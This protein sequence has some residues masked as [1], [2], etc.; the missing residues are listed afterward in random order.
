M[1][2]YFQLFFILATLAPTVLL[3]ELSLVDL[4]IEFAAT[5]VKHDTID[6]IYA[7]YFTSGEGAKLP[8][9]LVEKVH[10]KFISSY[11]WVYYVP[12]IIPCPKASR[13]TITITPDSK[14]IIMIFNS[15]TIENSHSICCICEKNS[16]SLT[17]LLDISGNTISGAINMTVVAPNSAIIASATNKGKIIIWEKI[18]LNKKTIWH[19]TATI[20]TNDSIKS[21]EFSTDSQLLVAKTL[22]NNKIHIFSKN[23]KSLKESDSR[24]LINTIESETPY[25]EVKLSPDSQYII[26]TLE[27]VSTLYLWDRATNWQLKELT[28]HQD[29]VK[30]LTILNNGNLIVSGSEDGTLRVWERAKDW[31]ST[32]LTTYTSPIIAITKAYDDSFF[33]P[34]TEDDTL[35]VWQEETTVH[36]EKTK[37]SWKQT[38]L[39]G[40]SD[41]VN[42]MGVTPDNSSI[43]VG[44][45]DTLYIYSKEKNWQNPTLAIHNSPPWTTL[46]PLTT[47]PLVARLEND[48]CCIWEKNDTW[49]STLMTDNSNNPNS[50]ALK[51]NRVGI[52]LN[53][54]FIVST[55]QTEPG[56]RI[57]HKQ[58]KWISTY[59]LEHDVQ[60]TFTIAPD[61]SYIASISSAGVLCI[62]TPGSIAYILCRLAWEKA[63]DTNE[64]QAVRNSTLFATLP[65]FLKER[66]HCPQKHE[67]PRATS[68]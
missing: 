16:L 41:T 43:I 60:P 33:V 21:L 19:C 64:K 18:E 45:G 58:K 50:A 67:S 17:Q 51:L 44:A 9:E 62:Y 35:S 8:T 12:I 22:S 32:L 34:W 26:A 25:E 39:T 30:A 10:K 49:E 47:F 7:D 11:Q 1:R 29:I 24:W 27:R 2:V 53:G 57:W 14:Y 59:C 66:F 28:G 42:Y 38:H 54:S 13:P 31:Q 6:R 5:L 48:T 63:K 3:S 46:M 23:N 68:E 55:M 40:Y 15:D 65:E 61:S 20:A 4:C 36:K 52:A 56:I 37:K